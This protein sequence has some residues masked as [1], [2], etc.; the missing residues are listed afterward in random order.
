MLRCALWPRMMSSLANIL[1][2]LEN[3]LCSA[4]IDR[5][6]PQMSTRSS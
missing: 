1:C 2:E 6:I 3:N 5:T 4:M